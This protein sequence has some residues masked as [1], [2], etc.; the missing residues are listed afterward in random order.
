MIVYH[1]VAERIPPWRNKVDLIA[2]QVLSILRFCD[3][4]Y[5]PLDPPP[6]P[7]PPARKPFEYKDLS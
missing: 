7:P 1:Y 2:S 5:V 3:A 4:T 6:H